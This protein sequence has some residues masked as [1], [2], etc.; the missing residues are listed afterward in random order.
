MNNSLEL[1]VD[2]LGK[3]AH[4][5]VDTANDGAGLPMGF[6]MHLWG[7]V[8]LG[9]AS[10]TLKASFEAGRLS[11]WEVCTVLFDKVFKAQFRSVES[12][13]GSLAIQA[14]IG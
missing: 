5:A 7:A 2:P 9:N 6:L 3:V 4:A 10:G 12:L 11:S 13:C 1:D 14:A 8:E